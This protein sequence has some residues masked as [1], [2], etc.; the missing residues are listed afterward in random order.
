MTVELLHTWVCFTHF[1]QKTQEKTIRTLINN[2]SWW[3]FHNRPIHAHGHHAGT[4]S[5]TPCS[6]FCS[7]SCFDHMQK[8]R[9]GCPRTFSYM[10]MWAAVPGGR[11][12]GCAALILTILGSYCLFYPCR[13]FLFKSLGKCLEK[14]ALS[15][16]IL[17]PVT[18]PE[19]NIRLDKAVVFFFNCFS[20]QE[21]RWTWSCRFNKNL[22]LRCLFSLSVCQLFAHFSEV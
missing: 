22:F 18:S 6:L 3:H 9:P 13:W 12:G 5:I 15:L 21:D 20:I 16:L 2:E 17:I 4:S 7:I 1:T 10:K 19:D 8:A 14:L 11:R